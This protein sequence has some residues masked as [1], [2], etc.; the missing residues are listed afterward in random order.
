MNTYL[1]IAL[2]GAAGGALRVLVG[3]WAGRLPVHGFPFGI[4]VVNVTGSLLLGLLLPL[5]LHPGWLAT[6]SYWLLVVGLCGSYTTVS[7]F[8]LQT[9]SLFEGGRNPMAGLYI[10]LSLLACLGAAA[11]GL[12]LGEGII[13]WSGP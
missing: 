6:E 3:V 8:A 11:L 5:V 2:G 1:A 9:V 12:W 7:T 4:W 10:G 13:A